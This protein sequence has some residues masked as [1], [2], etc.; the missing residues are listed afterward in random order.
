MKKILSYLTTFLLLF[1]CQNKEEKKPQEYRTTVTVNGTTWNTDH[2]TPT[3]SGAH[4]TLYYYPSSKL[5]TLSIIN[6]GSGEKIVLILKTPNALENVTYKFDDKDYV[7]NYYL[8]D[9][10]K[11]MN[12]KV[13]GE[14]KINQLAFNNGTV[15]NFDANFS[16][17]Q[18]ALDI[19][20]KP[21][22]H[23]IENARVKNIK[24]TL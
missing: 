22:T 10:S 2:T 18:E 23:K 7:A 15:S 4:V 20:S 19:E 17:T 13:V 1:A 6:D 11:L 12:K 3:P 8:K 16:F 5:L 9:E 21:Y 14:I 24:Q